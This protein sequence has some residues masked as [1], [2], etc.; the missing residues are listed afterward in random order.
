MIEHILIDVIPHKKQRYETVG[1]W[2]YSGDSILVT[3]SDTGNVQY[4]MLIA[5]HEVVEAIACRLVGVPQDEVDLFDFAYAGSGEPGDQ[6]DCPYY[7][8]HQLATLVERAAAFFFKVNWQSYDDAINQ[9]H[10]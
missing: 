3:V 4:N 1:D 6:F 9:L 8:E 7:W 5:I 10:R 2:Q